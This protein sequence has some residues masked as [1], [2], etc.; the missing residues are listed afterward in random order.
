MKQKQKIKITQ[1]ILGIALI[2]FAFSSG[3]TLAGFLSLVTGI[4]LI[5]ITL[6]PEKTEK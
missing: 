3:F 1:L 6:L 4:L 2:G 5:I